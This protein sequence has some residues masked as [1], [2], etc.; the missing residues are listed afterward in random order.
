[1][2]IRPKLKWKFAIG[3]TS[4]VPNSGG[5]IHYLIADFDGPIIN[6]PA[7]TG[8][9]KKAKAILQV[10]ANGF[11]LYT[12]I[13]MTFESLVS[14]LKLIKADPAWI[15]IGQKRGYFFLADKDYINFT[16]SVEHMRISYVKE[17][18]QNSRKA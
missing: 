4:R 7:L 2:A 17:K 12:N 5:K 8:T 3:T 10:T 6:T 15:R 1:M 11:H 16:W 9:V 18:A 14:T 13:Q